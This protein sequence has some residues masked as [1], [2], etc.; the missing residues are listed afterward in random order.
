MI[1][2][3]RAYIKTVI[4]MESSSYSP[5]SDPIGDDNLSASELANGYKV[6][7]GETSTETLPSSYTDELPVTIE[8]YKKSGIGVKV[9]TDYDQLY[10]DAMNIRDRLMKPTQYQD[11]ECF[12][13]VRPSSISVESINTNDKVFKASVTLTIVRDYEF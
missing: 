12:N 3:V 5:I 9:L 7:F 1:A 2:N 8:I 6:L 11:Q 10:T 13:F 4:Q